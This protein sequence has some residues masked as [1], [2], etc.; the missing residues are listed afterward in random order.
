MC[1]PDAGDAPSH[2]ALETAATERWPASHAVGV[3][4]KP[5][6]IDPDELRTVLDLT[7]VAFGAGPRA[8]DDYRA[9]AELVVEPDRTFVVD[10]GGVLAG[11][12]STFSFG[13]ALPG[14]ATVPAAAI[15]EVGVLPSHRR[16]GI[17]GSLMA[18]V[19]DQAVEWGEPVAGLTAS[20]GGIY[21]R[22][23]F[24]VATRFQSLRLDTWRAGTV[25]GAAIGSRDVT[26]GV[27]LIDEDEAARALPA[28]WEHHWRRIPGEL[29][30]NARWWQAL[31]LDP[32]SER[33]GASRR[34]VVVH[35]S[36]GG[37]PPDGCA[38]Y[39]IRQGWADDGTRH[40][41]RVDTVA[42][43]D[44][45]VMASLVRFLIDLDLVG[46]LRWDRAP[47]DLPLRW[48]LADPRALVTS[49]ERDHLWLR[50][51]DVARCLAA[52][53]Y[54]TAG[55]LVVEVVDPVRPE[56]GGRFLLDAGPE[57]A[58]CRR[59]DA[60][61]DVVV[62]VADLG[63]LLLSGVAWATLQRAGLVDEGRSGAVDRAD[64]LFRPR[65]APFCGT[66]F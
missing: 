22:F 47:L 41:L 28:V 18:A 49:G 4:W 2:V 54:A 34:F 52:R 63:A 44:D 36:P 33:E 59:T 50:P 40:E 15:T 32:E 13:L 27:R 16:R 5:R 61:A 39:R 29:S 24:G 6:L 56:V 53:S 21:R 37:G 9:Q 3:T 57:G 66:D 51:L 60:T 19:V 58:E 11:T 65:R 12:A 1:A 20:E 45:G 25:A 35:E 7:A 43:A 31:A 23:G 17:F 30:R 48:Q 62:H 64:A 55:T 46:T 10:D 14:S 26:G 8:P 38:I 42:G